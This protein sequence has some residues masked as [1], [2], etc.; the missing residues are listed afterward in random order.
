MV[1]HQALQRLGG[2]EREKVRL[3]ARGPL[4]RARIVRFLEKGHASFSEFRLGRGRHLGMA[5]WSGVARKNLG[6]EAYSLRSK[7]EGLR[8]PRARWR[9]RK[10]GGRKGVG[11]Q[12]GLGVFVFCRG[13]SASRGP[14]A[15]RHAPS[16]AHS[17]FALAE[18]ARA[19]SARARARAGPSA[20]ALC[21]SH[22][23]HFIFFVSS[24]RRRFAESR[25]QLRRRR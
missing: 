17:A 16:A 14:W 8:P 21:A 25:T 6:G 4:Q 13:P 1:S 23:T 24:W 11:R 12:D 22:C 7:A 9:S 19:C 15:K 3:T 20:F 5:V 10:R 18:L 2:A